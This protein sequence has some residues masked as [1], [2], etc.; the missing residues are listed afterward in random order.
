MLVK[1]TDDLGHLRFYAREALI[2]LAFK[3]CMEAIGLRRV[4]DKRGLGLDQRCHRFFEPITA[5][6]RCGFFCQRGL[7]RL[8]DKGGVAIGRVSRGG[9]IRTRDFLLPKQAR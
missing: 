9:E 2:R 8:G 1:H 7:Q 5:V 6:R 4:S 3:L